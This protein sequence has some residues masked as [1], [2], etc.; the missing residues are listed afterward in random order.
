M[1]IQLEIQRFS[2]TPCPLERSRQCIRDRAGIP[3]AFEQKP[4]VSLK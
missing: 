2:L 4:P 1:I 3:R